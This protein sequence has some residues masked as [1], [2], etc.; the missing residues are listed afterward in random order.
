MPFDKCM[1]WTVRW[2]WEFWEKGALHPI[3]LMRSAGKGYL[4]FWA[5]G[6]IRDMASLLLAP[7]RQTTLLA[8][9]R[10]PRLMTHQATSSLRLEE[11]TRSSTPGPRFLCNPAPLR[12]GLAF[13][14]GCGGLR[15]GAR[16]P[17]CARD[18]GRGRRF[19]NANSVSIALIVFLIVSFDSTL[20]FPGEGPGR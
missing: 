11:I 9:A 3:G 1:V 10:S 7:T 19:S 17:R 5:G 13:T 14:S 6:T 12:A 16:G 8:L 4:L 2:D 20:G 18:G 15:R